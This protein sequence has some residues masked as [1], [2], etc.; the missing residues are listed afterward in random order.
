MKSEFNK[1]MVIIQ[2]WCSFYFLFQSNLC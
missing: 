1:I 2:I